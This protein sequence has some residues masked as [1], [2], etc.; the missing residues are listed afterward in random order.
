M[1][2]TPTPPC[3]RT[4]P[5]GDAITNLC[6][7]CG[8]YW[9]L[10]PADTRPCVMCALTRAVGTVAEAIDTLRRTA[11]VFTTA[12]QALRDLTTATHGTEPQT[13]LDP[14]LTAPDPDLMAS[15]EGDAKG[16]AELREQARRHPGNQ[17]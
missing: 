11:A 17:P 6:P 14:R 3:G 10:H 7:G 5:H 13:P 15:P 4:P 1:T 2:L 16:L 8:H 12:T 9:L